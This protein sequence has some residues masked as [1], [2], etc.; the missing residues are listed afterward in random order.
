MFLILFSPLAPRRVVGLEVLHATLTR[1][2]TGLAQQRFGNVDLWMVAS[3]LLGS[4]SGVM[5]GSRLTIR[6]PARR[7]RMAPPWSSSSAVWRP[8]ATDDEAPT[9]AVESGLPSHHP[10]AN[11]CRR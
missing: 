10:G 8:S 9:D 5:R 7:L 6:A 3:L 11:R 1:R 4:A 2:V